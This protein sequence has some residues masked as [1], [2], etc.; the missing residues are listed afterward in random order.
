MSIKNCKHCDKQIDLDSE[1]EHEEGAAHEI[2]HDI[3]NVIGYW[4]LLGIVAIGLIVTMR[5]KLKN[6]ILK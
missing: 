5:K 3:G 1:V 4:P 6:W 2:V